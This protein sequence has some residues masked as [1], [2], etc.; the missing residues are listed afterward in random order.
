MNKEILCFLNT[1][2]K[3]ICG[4]RH[5]LSF[6]AVKIFLVS[7]IFVNFLYSLSAAPNLAD[8]SFESKALQ[9]PPWQGVSYE[10]DRFSG[11]SI[12]DGKFSWVGQLKGVRSGFVSLGKVGD[13]IRLTVSFSDGEV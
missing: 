9:L 13:E 3:R 7:F 11:V 10:V 6:L 8:I 12:S 2:K 4:I 5:I 1:T